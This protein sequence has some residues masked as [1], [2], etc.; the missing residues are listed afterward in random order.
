MTSARSHPIENSLPGCLD[1]GKDAWH[2]IRS[3][4]TT[5]ALRQERELLRHAN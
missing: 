5:D 3:Q 4:I 2:R 1:L